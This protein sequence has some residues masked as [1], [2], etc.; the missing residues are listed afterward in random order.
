MYTTN[1]LG[2]VL[3][4]HLLESNL[5]PTA[6]VVL[7]SSTGSYCAAAHFL[8]GEASGRVK[9]LEPG[10]IAQTLAKDKAILG[11]EAESSVPA[12][13]LTK[14][15]QMVFAAH[16]QGHFDAHA[17]PA[18]S[19]R[20]CRTAHAFT[21]G[22]TSTPILGKFDV[23]WQTWFTNPLFAMLKTTGK[24]IA[25]GTDEGAKTGPWL[26]TWGNEI[27]KGK[28]GGVF[29]GRMQKRT[30]LIDLMDDNRKADEW[31]TWE[32]DAGIVWSVCYFSDIF[33]LL[34][35]PGQRLKLHKVTRILRLI[36]KHTIF[37]PGRCTHSNATRSTSPR[38]CDT[39][40]PFSAIFL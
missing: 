28:Q 40:L 22:F 30:S 15:Q 29:W 23:T 32:R 35:C 18:S 26:A 36:T 11:L 2:S 20:A 37:Q 12:Y 34:A 1:F 9:A 25:V 31:R 5:S 27:G 21:P 4:T 19:E 17:S 38:L 24:W 8:Q 39:F 7:T 10:I 3:M 16:L 6:K 13:G 14:A 33:A